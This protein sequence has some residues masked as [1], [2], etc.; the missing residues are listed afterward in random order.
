MLTAMGA[1][2]LEILGVIAVAAMPSC[3]TPSRMPVG[4]WNWPIQTI[5]WRFRSTA[6]AARL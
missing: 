4:S 3:T 5:G 2:E 1:D 6:E